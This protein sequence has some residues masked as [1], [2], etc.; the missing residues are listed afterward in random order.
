[1]L[2][3]GEVKS[4]MLGLLGVTCLLSLQR[5]LL[6]A[7]RLGRSLW[8]ITVRATATT[9]SPRQPLHTHCHLGNRYTYTVS[10]ATNNTH[11]LAESKMFTRSPYMYMYSEYMYSEQVTILESAT[12]TSVCV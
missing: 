6:R 4:C 9:W 7:V 3:G 12:V 1:M 5:A 8:E 2:G 11:T 10:S